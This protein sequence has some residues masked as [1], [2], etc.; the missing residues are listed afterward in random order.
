L[1]RIG[2][3]LDVTHQA[4]ANWINRTHAQLNSAPPLIQSAVIELDELF[5]FVQSK[6]RSLRCHRRG[7]RHAL[8]R[9]LVG[10]PTAHLGKIPGCGGSGTEGSPLF[11]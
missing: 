8:F 1:R 11:Q 4:V 3:L 7:S 5:T 6:K 10:S 9:R 2:R